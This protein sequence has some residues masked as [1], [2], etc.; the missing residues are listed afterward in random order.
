M[1]EVGT[2]SKGVGSDL[3]GKNDDFPIGQVLKKLRLAN[4][5][6]SQNNHSSDEADLHPTASRR[7]GPASALPAG[8]WRCAQRLG[9]E[10]LQRALGCDCEPTTPEA[11]TAFHQGWKPSLEM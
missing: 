8:P 4:S 2:V 3:C 10:R 1:E 6:L 5:P 7:V 11:K 9:T